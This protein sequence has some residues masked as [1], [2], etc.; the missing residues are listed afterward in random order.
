MAAGACQMTSLRVFQSLGTAAL[1]V[2]GCSRTTASLGARCGG[3]TAN[4]STT[5][6]G[7][8]M[9]RNVKLVASAVVDEAV[10]ASQVES[11][12]ESLAM[13][14]KVLFSSTITS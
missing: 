11:G 2:R 6:W 1:D 4:L 10:S 14:F 13:Y 12:V 9:R 8:R 3:F 7:Q 5:G